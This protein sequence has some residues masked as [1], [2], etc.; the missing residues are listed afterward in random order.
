MTD[1]PLKAVPLLYER[2]AFLDEA[3]PYLPLGTRPTPVA[4]LPGLADGPADVWIKDESGYGDIA[5]GNKVRKLEWII[6]DALARRSPAILTFGALGTNHGLATAR[7]A[8]A[9]GLGCA[10]ALVD[11]PID[12]HVRLQLER[13]EAS[14]A[15]VHRTRTVAR[16]YAAAPWLMM[17]HG[18]FREGRFRPAYLLP[19]GGS[20]PVGVLGYVEAGLEIATQVSA[21]LLPE[22]SYVVLPVGSGGTAAG[23]ALG[24]RFA[25]LRTRVL[26][27]V[28]NDQLTL[29]AKTIVGLANKTARLLRKR[30]GNFTIAGLQPED[31]TLRR[32]WLGPGYGH[33]TPA[34]EQLVRTSAA[35]D[36]P[37]L[38]PVYTAKALAAL[39]DLNTRRELGNGTVLYLHTYGPR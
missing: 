39:K 38:E 37:V 22:P 14:G 30:T 15:V 7:Y 4:P 5:G 9:H 34:A 1:V 11:Q 13:L 28:V 19:T 27:I 33:P 23:L 21:G 10:L 31:V 18:A 24:L 16:T 25:G 3:V 12:D 6:P 35:A 20:S 8:R 29:D 26:G 2:Y 36:G 32:D 17:R